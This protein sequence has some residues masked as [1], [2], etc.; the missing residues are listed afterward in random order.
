MKALVCDGTAARVVDHPEPA[1]APGMAL[2]RVVR[3]GICNTDLE[4]VKGYMSFRGVLGHELVGSVVQGPAAWQGKRVV[5]EINFA[6]GHCDTCARGLGRHCPTRRV[7]GI[8]GADGAMAEICA[9]PVE[10]L[11]AVPDE[12]SDD[13]AAFV[14]PL[15][16]ALGILEQVRIEAGDRCLVLGDGKL[17]LLVALGLAQAGARVLAVG[18]HEAKLAILRARGVE[19]VLLGEW[20]REPAGV[21]I[22]A[23]GSP[24]GFALAASVTRPRGTLVLKSTVGDISAVHLAPLV[25]HEITVVGSRCGSFPPAI[26][27]LAARRVDVEPLISARLPLRDAERALEIAAQPGILKVLLHP[28]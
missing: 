19:T 8:Q 6:C 22:E 26:A 2:V 25:I 28:E 10:N 12:I 18:K 15:A 1:A 17:G 7:M 21:V 13:E 16:A 24:E 5:A 27:A 3:A 23:T 4:L 9:V 11:H 14:E 20:K